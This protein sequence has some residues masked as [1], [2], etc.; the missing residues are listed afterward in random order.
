ML[1][2]QLL[3][4]KVQNALIAKWL[5]TELSQMS[6]L[7]VGSSP[8]RGMRLNLPIAIVPLRCTDY[9]ILDIQPPTAYLGDEQMLRTLDRGCSVPTVTELIFVRAQIQLLFRKV[10]NALIAKWLSTAL[11]QEEKQ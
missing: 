4:R 3:F 9:W 1:L 6:I 7:T 10:Q 5:S 8:G 11:S 2:I